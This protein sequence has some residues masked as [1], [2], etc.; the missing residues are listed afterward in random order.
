MADAEGIS[1]EETN[2]I[3][4]SLGLKPLTDDKAPVADKEKE[5]E[6][7]YSKA[8]DKERKARDDKA[9][10]DKIAKVRNRHELNAKLKGTTLGTLGEEEGDTRSWIKRNKK[11]VK[12]LAK[13]KQKELEE[14]DNQFQESY[15]EDDLAGLK[16]AHDLEGMEEGQ[17]QIL[18]L[19]DARIL[20]DAEDELQ[21]VL[22]A[23][24]ERTDERIKNKSKNRTYTGYDDEEFAEGRAGMKRKILSKYDEDLDGP[25]ETGFRLGSSAKPAK[26][27]RIVEDMDAPTVNKELL[28]IDYL[29]NLDTSDYLQ[30]GDVGFKKQK[31]KKRATRRVVESDIVPEEPTEQQDGMQVDE[32]PTRKA[33]DNF[34]DDDELQAALARSRKAKVRKIPKLTAEEI[35]KRVAEER[36]A[37][38][39]EAIKTEEEVGLV[40]DDTTEFMDSLKQAMERP[41]ERRVVV[42][43]NTRTKEESDEDEDQMEVELEAGEVD[44]KQEQEM[45]ALKME[46]DKQFGS[47]EGVKV[48]EQEIEVGTAAEKTHSGATGALQTSTGDLRE[49]ERIQRERDL[50]L[51]EQRTRAALRELERAAARGANRDQQ[52]REYENRLR[53]QNE[54][55]SAIKSFENYKPDINIVYHDEF[56]REMTPKEAWKALSHRFHGKG[57]G[58]AKTEK[59]LKKIAEEQ[60]MQ[61]MVSGE[62]PLGMTSAFQARQ[63]KLGQA[64]MVLSVGNRGAAPQLAQYIET[65]NLTKTKAEKKK[66]GKDVDKGMEQPALMDVTHFVA[67]AA[68]ALATEQASKPAAPKAKFAPVGSFV[69]TPV[70]AT[71]GDSTPI[72]TGRIA[73]NLKRKAEDEGTGTPPQKRR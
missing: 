32:E 20:D 48:E 2:K 5:A 62:T 31:K 49:R 7:N 26:A 15:G 70:A 59:R 29:K 4:I 38:E 61:A 58:K 53:E 17:E 65:P 25:Q 36:E 41:A 73:L 12:E 57:S 23:E 42:I 72:S 56:G 28:S 11:M 67:A 44:A 40:I 47:D 34:V 66:K 18:T 1:L 71:N 13:R 60:K 8:R 51:A 16:V 68:P 50:W 46:L 35:A 55:R 21:N 30:E 27:A 24:H 3:R 22:L 69:P 43:N 39:K 45:L 63:E 6:D 37:E 9:L 52:Q 64:H 14:M 19:K 10:R 33:D 54:I